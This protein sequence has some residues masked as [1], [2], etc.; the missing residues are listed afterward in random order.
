MRRAL[1]IALAATFALPAGAYAGAINLRI[2]ADTGPG[3]K[4]RRATLTCDAK[5]P[6]ATGFL[7]ARDAQRLCRRAYALERFLGRA[8]SREDA[9]TEVYGGPSRARVRGNVRGTAVDR[10]FAR[11]DGCEI[12]D[13]QRAR[14]LLPRPAAP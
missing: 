7:R 2:D 11:R 9:C 4:V 13:W 3:T 1:L 8:P 14:L 10:R 6:R 12:G 5:G